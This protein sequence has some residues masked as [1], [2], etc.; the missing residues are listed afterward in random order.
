MSS[1][2]DEP[3]GGTGPFP[4]LRELLH[5][6]DGP[7]WHILP[8]WKAQGENIMLNPPPAPR[9]AKAEYVCKKGHVRLEHFRKDGDN[10]TCWECY[11]EWLHQQ[12]SMTLIKKEA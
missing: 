2:W 6:Y 5:A 9:L 7:S 12:F 1:K 3:T 10:P 8:D 4:A 11:E